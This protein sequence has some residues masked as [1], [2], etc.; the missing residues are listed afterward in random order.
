MHWLWSIL[1][2]LV[3]LYIVSLVIYMLLLILIPV[4]KRRF[5]GKD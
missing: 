1:D 3:E 2:K 5:V 4:E